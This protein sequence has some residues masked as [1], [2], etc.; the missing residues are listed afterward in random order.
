MSLESLAPD[1]RAVV[2]LVLQQERSYDDLAGLLGI[3]TEAVRERARAGLERVGGSS[4]DLTD[5]EL[6]E[7]ADYLLGQQSVSRREA[8]RSLLSS[9]SDARR[10]ANRVSDALEDV[11]RS[12][13]PGVP[14]EDDFEDDAA[15]SPTTAV[16]APEPTTAPALALPDEDDDDE[17]D[18][19]PAEDRTLVSTSD[20]A[21]VR[22]RPRPRPREDA[23][24][25]RPGS[26]GG[27]DKAKEARPRASR[28]GGALLIAGIAVM[29]AVAV[30]FLLRDG[31]EKEP[32]TVAE[33]TPTATATAEATPAAA[34][35]IQLTAPDG[36]DA[37]GTM[38][39]LVSQDGKIQFSIEGTSLPASRQGE[40]YAVWLTGGPKPRRLGF[41]P[42]VGNDGK[43]GV[44]GPREGAED[45]FLRDFGRARKVIISR[46]T[47][48]D[49]KE[50]G[51][52]VM[53]GEIPRDGNSG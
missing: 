23:A 52:V 33:N 36:G 51:P 16:P 1:Q 37:K 17:E 8:T 47:S 20:E 9:S 19:E 22:A 3:S 53:E 6:G 42:T 45:A 25:P 49:A 46:E 24:R 10:W 26:T 11:A 27:S 32:E 7:I 41:A 31:D 21:L 34:G 5:E 29:L 4:G 28:I 12:P 40:A 35:Q 38:T 13:L 14:D 48:Q 18:D 50:P 39:I 30:I 15:V 2:Q 44:S 43:L